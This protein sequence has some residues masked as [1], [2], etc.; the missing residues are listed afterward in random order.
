MQ[1]VA[2]RA[3]APTSTLPVS[4]DG[5]GKSRTAAVADKLC[6]ANVFAAVPAVNRTDANPETSWAVVS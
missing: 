5:T 3:S 1:P 2:G 6:S 4:V